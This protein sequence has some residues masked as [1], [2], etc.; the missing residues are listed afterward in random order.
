MQDD[1][2]RLERIL[3]RLELGAAAAVEGQRPVDVDVPEYDRLF[4]RFRQPSLIRQQPT[5]T[6]AAE[7]AAGAPDAGAGAGGTEPTGEAAS[8]GEAASAGDTAPADLR[9]ALRTALEEQDLP[10]DVRQELA[11]R[12]ERKLILFPDQIRGDVIPQYGTEA[13]GLDY[14]GKIRLI[15]QAIG[16]GDLLEVIMRASSGSPQR[17]LVQPREIVESGDDLMLRARQEPDHQAIR[18]PDSPHLTGCGALS[19][20]LLRRSPR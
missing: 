13:R 16:N 19:G 7:R 20:T 9:T 1:T 4:Q 5:L 11:L 12:I 3:T 2:R 17:V 15:E 10:E 8:G 14:L 6:P 18:I